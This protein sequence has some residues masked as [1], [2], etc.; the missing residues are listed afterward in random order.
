MTPVLFDPLHRSQLFP[1][2]RTRPVA[3]LRKGI[4]DHYAESWETITWKITP[5]Y[6]N[7][8]VYRR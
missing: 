5:P 7:G 2:T 3:D 8:A 6:F 4:L 1:F